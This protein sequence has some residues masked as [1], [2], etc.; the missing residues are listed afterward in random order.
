MSY[1]EFDSFQFDDD[2]MVLKNNG[3]LVALEPKAKE[4]LLAFLNDPKKR[5]S[6]DELLEEVWPGK[7]VEEGNLAV[8]ISA[9]RDT[10]AKG[11]SGKD[12]F[13]TVHR[14]GYRFAADV[15]VR[16]LRQLE[17]PV[18]ASS[19]EQTVAAELP[20]GEADSVETPSSQ[21]AR[22]F[23]SRWIRKSIIYLAMSPVL[24]ALVVIAISRL[25]ASLA[26]PSHIS[27]ARYVQL[28][29]DA[30]EKEDGPLL[31]DGARVYFKEEQTNGDVFASVA[32]GGGSTGHIPLPKGDEDIYDLYPQTSELLVGRRA[33]DQLDRE[34]WVVPLLGPSPR[35][36]GDLRADSASWSPYQ[37][38]IAFTLRKSLYVANVDGSESRK[39]A[40]APGSAFSPRWSPNAKVIRF[41]ES[42]QQDGSIS[43]TI[44]EVG[45]D[46]SNLHPLLS[47]WNNPPHEC[48]GV[49]TP[50]GKFY[51]FQSEHGGRKDLWAISEHRGLFGS[52]SRSPVR[53]SFASQNFFSP[54]IGNGG[55]QVF[56]IGTDR[57]GE[58]V[59]YDY[60]LKTFMPF[61]G[62]I[63][64]TWVS[65]S[66]S[67]HSVAYIDYRDRSIWR[68][69]AD[70]SQKFQI[71]FPPF[72]V[73]DLAWSPD[74]KTL[75]L[76]GRIPGK[77][78]IIYLVPSTGG[79]CK[80]L[81]PGNTEQGIPT[82]SADGTRIAFG[83]VPHVF[84]K[85]SGGEAIHILELS[86]HA[87][88]E[89]P[90]SRG[91]WSSRWSPDGH[92]L[93]ALTIEE[94]RVMLYDFTTKKWRSTDAKAV[95][96]PTW[97]SDS[98][99]IYFDTNIHDQA[100]RR[101]RVA[102]GHVD[103][104]TRLHAY[105]DLAWWWSGVTPDNSPLILRNLGS[106]EIYSLALE[107]R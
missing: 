19:T 59:R 15:R 53:L 41:S 8:Q 10:L 11:S 13:E 66:K 29:N 99:Y 74:E 68:A 3:R 101:L 52:T 95:N 102:D 84:S 82:W 93:S 9:L 50:D 49:W 18:P 47:G 30:Q 100:L 22:S 31:T 5:F 105:P 6:K 81:I 79:D 21:P 17:A 86:N 70:G 107:Y 57:R 106:T 71:T 14:H 39:I 58:L 16:D 63:S 89:L 61:L 87:V 67:R 12:Y 60:K 91:L 85:P 94:Q 45:V 33:S 35:R 56:A 54:A 27:V 98:K 88:T 37:H 51:V 40:D 97:S 92:S 69:N 55:K 38:K 76:R 90:E 1:Y 26:G 43:Q 23:I 32:V 73:D 25:K 42:W 34:L 46:G 65:F 36:I 44:W 4:L 64:A 103:L 83:D 2:G 78:W 20:A 7:I 96:N 80:A 77:P 24:I 62:G 28:T 104:L 75:A 48:C 72:E